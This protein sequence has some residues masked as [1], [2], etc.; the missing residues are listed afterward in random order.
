MLPSSVIIGVS[1]EW[2]NARRKVDTS[3]EVDKATIVIL[4]CLQYFYFCGR[5]RENGRQGME[6][7]LIT[8]HCHPV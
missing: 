6:L 3:V 1:E 4:L 7:R 2:G 8:T 5:F